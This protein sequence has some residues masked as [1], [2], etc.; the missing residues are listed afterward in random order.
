MLPYLLL[1]EAMLKFTIVA[2][3]IFIVRVF[4]LMV[5][6]KPEIRYTIMSLPI[7]VETL[8]VWM[9]EELI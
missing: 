2:L 3:L 6:H 9:P 7:A 5:E 4:F 1:D 8:L